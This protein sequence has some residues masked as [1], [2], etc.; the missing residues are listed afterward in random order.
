MPLEFEFHLQYPCHSPTT[1]LSVFRQSAQSRIKCKCTQT[2]KWN[3]RH[4]PRVMT[5]LPVSSP[6]INILHQLFQ[7]PYSNSRDIVASSPSFPTHHPP[8]STPSAR[9]PRRAR[10]QAIIVNILRESRVSFLTLNKININDCNG[11]KVKK[12]FELPRLTDVKTSR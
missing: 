8:P 6:Q 11:M 1:K 7:C 4:C 2:S 5:S 3:M 9:V 10:S 12:L